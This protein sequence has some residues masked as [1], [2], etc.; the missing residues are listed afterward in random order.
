MFNVTGK[1]SKL[2]LFLLTINSSYALIFRTK[3][4]SASSFLIYSIMKKRELT[5]SKKGIFWMENLLPFIL[6]QFPYTSYYHIGI[7]F[8]GVNSSLSS[9]YLISFWTIRNYKPP[10]FCFDRLCLISG[11]HD[12]FT[13]FSL[14]LLI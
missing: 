9:V 14:I 7:H 2:L 10:V 5:K 12:P 13:S 6:N 4:R 11:L 8:D 3:P 1:S